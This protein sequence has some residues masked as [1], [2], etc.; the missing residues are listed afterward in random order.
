MNEQR[1][2][3]DFVEHHDLQAP[4]AYRALDLVSEVGEVAKEINLST[5]YGDLDEVAVAS[6]EIGDCLFT[7]LALA[8]TVGVDAG[9]ALEEAI[10]KY[11]SRLEDTGD[12]GSG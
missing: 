3:A 12:A 5:G 8:E 10:E 11:E 1:L 2:V 7:L 4:P 9:E 6:D